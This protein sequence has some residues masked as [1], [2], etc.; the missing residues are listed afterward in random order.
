[1]P[2][3]VL[4]DVVR[5]PDPDASNLDRVRIRRVEQADLL[6]V[7]RIE[8]RCFPQPW[9]FAAFEQFLDEPGFLVATGG[10]E[11]DV[12]GYV[13][14]DVTPN[15]GRDIGH[16]KDLAVHPGARGHGIGRRLLER[17]LSTLAAEGAM[18]VKLEVR[19]GNDVALDLYRDVGFENLREIR[20]YYE[21]GENALMMVLDLAEWGRADTDADID[22][23]TDGGVAPA[24]REALEQE[25]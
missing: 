4:R 17:A 20:G 6:S 12:F 5:P 14:S 24:D 3:V 10:D 23:D 16:V 2:S 13:V 21:D 11:G 7:F 18:L 19:A 15:Y 25:E 1:L 22:T 9:P 8:K